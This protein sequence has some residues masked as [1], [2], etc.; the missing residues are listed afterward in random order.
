MLHCPSIGLS[1]FALGHGPMLDAIKCSEKKVNNVTALSRSLHVH[2][3]P[4][5][6]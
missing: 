1:D 4:N 5:C 6:S 2:P 3:I